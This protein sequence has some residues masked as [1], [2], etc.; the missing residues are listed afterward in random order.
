[1]KFGMDFMPYVT[2]PFAWLMPYLNLLEFVW[3]SDDAIAHV[4]V[5]VRITNLI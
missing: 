4:H 2:A 3:R 5:R 1:M